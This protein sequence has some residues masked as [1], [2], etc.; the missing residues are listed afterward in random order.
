MTDW[1]SSYWLINLQRKC[2]SSLPSSCRQDACRSAS[3]HKVQHSRVSPGKGWIVGLLFYY[4][5]YFNLQQVQPLTTS[6]LS[7]DPVENPT[8]RS[9]YSPPTITT[10]KFNSNQQ[11]PTRIQLQAPRSVQRKLKTNKPKTLQM[12]FPFFFFSVTRPYDFFFFFYQK[13]I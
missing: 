1:K 2:T 6:Q 13:T 11:C 9:T 12:C 5:Y 8:S 4:H 10:N 7:R 3:I